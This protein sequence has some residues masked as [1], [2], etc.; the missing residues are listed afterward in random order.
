MRG[1]DAFGRIGMWIQGTTPRTRGVVFFGTPPTQVDF[2]AHWTHVRRYST[3]R[4]NISFV[5]LGVADLARSRAFY[6]SMGLEEHPSSN[7]HVAFFEMSGQLF[8]LFPGASSRATSV[9]RQ[10]LTRGVDDILKRSSGRGHDRLLARRGVW[11][12]RHQASFRTTLG[13]D[14]RVLR[15][16]RRLRLGACLE[17][18]DANRRRRS[19]ASRHE[20]SRS[21]DSMSTKGRS[22]PGA[23][24]PFKHRRKMCA[25]SDLRRRNLPEGWPGPVLRRCHRCSIL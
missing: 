9:D 5:T 18:E 2:M 20:L 21:S 1:E 24:P 25:G 17:S 13:R 6:V 19:G 15:R 8:A 14:A 7:E 11:R 16:S 22:A 3:L 4:A 23:L 10:V 12:N